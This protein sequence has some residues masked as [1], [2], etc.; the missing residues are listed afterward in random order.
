MESLQTTRKLTQQEATEVFMKY[1]GYVRSVAFAAAP[2]AS[3][4]EDIAHDAY[5]CFMENVATWDYCEEKVKPLLKSITRNMAARVWKSQARQTPE[6]LRA[7][8]EF[9]HTELIDDEAF[10]A[11]YCSLEDKLDALRSCLA[12]LSP[13]SRMLLEKLY[14]EENSYSDLAVLLNKSTEA[15]YMQAS[16][17]RAQLQDC[18]NGVLEAE[19]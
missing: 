8:A 17:A 19:Q 16:R 9:L 2:V 3:L 11:S 6:A 4:S 10:H 13:E 7:V 15:L 14:F 18:V 1:Y 5:V 12:K